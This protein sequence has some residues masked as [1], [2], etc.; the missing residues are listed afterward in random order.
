M[1]AAFLVWMTGAVETGYV[2]TLLRTPLQ[3]RRM[4]KYVP[5]ACLRD[6]L[7]PGVLGPMSDEADMQ[8]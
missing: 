1:H 5:T 7:F 6:A 8:T 4:K 3:P 2:V